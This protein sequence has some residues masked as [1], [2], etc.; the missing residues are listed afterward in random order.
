MSKILSGAGVPI[1]S[2]QL[3]SAGH[4]DD[5]RQ[6]LMYIAHLYPK[7][8]LLGVGFSLG[9]NVV[10]RYIAEEGEQSR[11]SAACALAC[12]WDLARNCNMLMSSYIGK[13]V[14]AKGMGSNLL[15]LLKKHSAP[16]SRDPE[17][18]VA[19]AL[20][21]AMSLKSP[22]LEEFDNTF[23]CV[24]GG[25]SPPFPFANATEYYNWSSSHTVLGSIRVPFLAINAAD[26]PVVQDVPMDGADN[27]NIVM[28]LTPKGGHLGWF[29]SVGASSVRRWVVQPVLEWL[30]AMVQTLPSEG[31]L[32]GRPMYVDAEGFLREEG[33]DKTGCRELEEGAIVDGTEPEEGLLQGL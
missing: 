19:R 21:R 29:E 14:Y 6:A 32:R 23:T 24:A 26:D 5:I 7:A 9:A 12:P 18:H 30:Q 11:L 27:G 16:L 33:N 2:Q 28:V 22:T 10:T 13:H 4:T 1:T 31:R 25:S 17:H 3:Y 8:P 20:V 15:N